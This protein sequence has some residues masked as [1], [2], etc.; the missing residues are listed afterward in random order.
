MQRG[1]LTSGDLAINMDLIIE[2]LVAVGEPPHPEA[3]HLAELA[4]GPRWTGDGTPRVRSRTR[5]RQRRLALFEEIGLDHYTAHAR[6]LR[7]AVD[8]S[9]DSTVFESAGPAG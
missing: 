3:L 4:P 1:L 8:E 5:A 9:E 7:A 2:A 6:C